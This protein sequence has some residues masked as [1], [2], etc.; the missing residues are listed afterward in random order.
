MIRLQLVALSLMQP[1]LALAWTP[2]ADLKMLPVM[3]RMGRGILKMLLAMVRMGRGILKMLL[4][5]VRM[6][7][8]ILRTLPV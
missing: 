1:L 8:G 5:M 2:L 3:V 7:R 6:G 4:V